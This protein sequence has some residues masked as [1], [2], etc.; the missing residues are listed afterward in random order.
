MWASVN[1]YPAKT[2]ACGPFLDWHVL[3]AITGPA[4]AQISPFNASESNSGR[5]R[6]GVFPGRA[7][8]I[9]YTSFSKSTRCDRATASFSWFRRRNNSCAS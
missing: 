5:G 4:H 6:Y 7:S 8:T 3:L 9:A 1:P 2:G